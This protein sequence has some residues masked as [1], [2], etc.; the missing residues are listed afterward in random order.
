MPVNGGDDTWTAAQWRS[1]A[2]QSTAR[3]PLELDAIVE[4]Q[5]AEG[6]CG[7]GILGQIG[8]CHVFD[9]LEVSRIP[10]VR[11]YATCPKPHRY[12]QPF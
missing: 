7:A 6:R 10:T 12:G 3:L 8:K 11:V 1:A 4:C 5:A 9:Q 2:T